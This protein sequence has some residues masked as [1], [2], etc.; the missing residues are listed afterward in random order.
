M[1]QDELT[2]ENLMELLQ[3]ASKATPGK[4]VDHSGSYY[5]MI[6]TKDG[7]KEI[8]VASYFNH[9]YPESRVLHDEQAANAAHI[10]AFSPETATALV[11]ELLRLRGV[12]V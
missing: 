4:W 10:A 9:V 12:N 6:K 3:I 11:K 1:E 8:A 5:G 2:N 7:K